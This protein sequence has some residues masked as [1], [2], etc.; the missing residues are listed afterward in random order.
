MLRAP[1][2]NDPDCG[3]EY[4]Y[5]QYHY[6][7]GEVAVLLEKRGCKRHSARYEQDYHSEILELLEKFRDDTFLFLA[8]QYVFA[9]LPEPL[10]RFARAQA[11]VNAAAEFADRVCGAHRIPV[12]IFSPF[13]LSPCNIYSIYCRKFTKVIE[14]FT[15]Q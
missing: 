6:R 10:L 8:A 15:F 11:P 7:V 1:L 5:Y 12:H 9:V 2:L 13:L 14:P 4:N 3:V